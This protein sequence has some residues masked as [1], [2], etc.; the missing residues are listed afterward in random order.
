[1]LTKQ[2]MDTLTTHTLFS[3]GSEM[4]IVPIKKVNDTDSLG[5]LNLLNEL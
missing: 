4:N 5:I 2:S 1:M 3:E